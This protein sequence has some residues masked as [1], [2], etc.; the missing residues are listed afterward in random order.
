M[1]SSNMVNKSH[2]KA[3][4]S[5]ARYMFYPEKLQS[6]FPCVYAK[7]MVEYLKS[8]PE[9]EVHVYH[10]YLLG[11]DPYTTAIK[12]QRD[13]A[14]INRCMIEVANFAYSFFTQE[15]IPRQDGSALFLSSDSS[16]L[17][18]EAKSSST[19]LIMKEHDFSYLLAE[20]YRLF[21]GRMTSKQ[22]MPRSSMSRLA[23]AAFGVFAFFMEEAMYVV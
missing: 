8:L 14:E 9:N 11:I 22:G 4:A 5:F 21:L 3:Q 23:L 10:D 16:A 20:T 15:F 17:T 7:F 6:P 19:E 2:S 18:E 1:I 12:L 13:V